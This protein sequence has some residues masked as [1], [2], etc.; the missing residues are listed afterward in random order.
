M[1]AV[2]RPP[3]GQSAHDRIIDVVAQL[4]ARPGVYNI[5]TNPGSQKNRWVGSAGVYPDLIGWAPHGGEDVAVWIAE[6]ETTDSVSAMEAREQWRRY[7]T[8]GAPL[9]LIVP[10]GYR[11]VAQKF[12][13]TAGVRLAG[14]HEWSVVNGYLQLS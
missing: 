5:A 1:V 10:R 6:V 14:I 9:H 8:A 12:A 4:W 2:K 11:A 7:S 3:D 13:V